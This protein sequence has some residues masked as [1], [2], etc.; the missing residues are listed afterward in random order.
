MLKW[1]ESVEETHFD[2]CS[3]LYLIQSADLP[4]RLSVR[5]YER[6]EIKHLEQGTHIPVVIDKGVKVANCV[7]PPSCVRKPL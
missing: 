1:F 5:V 4:Y 2:C 7:L 6:S 3:Q